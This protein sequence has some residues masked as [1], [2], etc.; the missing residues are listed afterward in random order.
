MSDTYNTSSG[1]FL[2]AERM[3]T[4]GTQNIAIGGFVY[5]KNI[6]T[7]DKEIK[8]DA[9]HLLSALTSTNSNNSLISNITVSN[10]S[11][12]EV[13]EPL[14]VSTHRNTIF[15]IVYNDIWQLYKNHEASVWHAHEVKLEKDISDWKKLTQDEQFFMER[16]LAFFA[17]SDLIVAENIVTKFM[18]EIQVTEAQFFYGF[19]L[20]MENIHSETYS[21]MIDTYIQDKEKKTIM[22]NAIENLP[23]VK[24]KADWAKKWITSDAPLAERLLAFAAV[25]GIFFS[26]AF[27]AIYWLVERG[28]MPGLAMGNDFISRDEA[29]HTDFAVL[30]Y[31]RY[32][33]NKVSQERFEEIYRDACEIEIEFITQSL[34]CSLLGM[35]AS[36]MKDYIR[37]VANR[38]TKQLGF[39]EIYP[40]TKQ[41][42]AFMDRLGIKSKS[43]FFEFTPSEY[44]KLESTDDTDAYGDI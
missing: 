29:L 42:F 14:T 16:V 43:N 13:V 17:S 40:N 22:F 31:T 12:V 41:P 33:V 4:S 19:Q 39:K 26:G 21:N 5:P 36:L 3:I 7:N 37:Y 15:P 24:K 6:V 9:E 38:L 27:C 18:K 11:L 25:E 1:N 10:T 2:L 35:N 34:P 23:C 32:I 8:D 30:L 20:A 28:I 44:N